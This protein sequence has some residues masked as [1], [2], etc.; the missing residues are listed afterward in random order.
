ML[1]KPFLILLSKYY[2]NLFNY[3]SLVN[4]NYN[5]YYKVLDLYLNI[6]S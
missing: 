3:E 1:G 2:Q 4:I 6:Y 5:I